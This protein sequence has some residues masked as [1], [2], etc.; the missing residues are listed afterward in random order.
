MS[1][2]AGVD[3]FYIIGPKLNRLDVGVWTLDLGIKVEW[4]VDWIERAENELA[5]RKRVGADLS[6]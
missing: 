5:M 1:H 2:S 3:K 6:I 4:I